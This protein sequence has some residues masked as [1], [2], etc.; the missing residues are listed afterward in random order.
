MTIFRSLLILTFLLPLLAACGGG[1]SY[2]GPLQCAPYARKLTGVQLRGSAYTWWYKSQ[3]K[4]PHTKQPKKGAILVFRKTSKLPDGHVS[5]VKKIK[6]SRTIIVDHANWDAQRV[7]HNASVVDV[8]S[9]NDWSLVRVWWPPT[10]KLGT[11]KYPTYGF[12]LP[13]KT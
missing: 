10:N 8:S 7:N 12:I 5:V 13:G 1:R 2:N 3:G 6:D 9:R 11:R 4:Y